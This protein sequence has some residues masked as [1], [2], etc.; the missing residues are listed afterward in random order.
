MWTDYNIVQPQNRKIVIN[1]LFDYIIDVDLGYFTITY[2][3]WFAEWELPS[4]INYA[5]CLLVEEEMNKQWW[6]SISQYKM[7]PRT[8]K[9]A[10]PDEDSSSKK[11]FASYINKYRILDI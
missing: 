2:M 10:S 11:G 9:Y 3:S 7:W 8:I 1:D 6:Q 5:Q 4:D